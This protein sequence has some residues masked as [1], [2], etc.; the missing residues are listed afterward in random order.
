MLKVDKSSSDTIIIPA[1]PTFLVTHGGDWLGS[2][3]LGSPATPTFGAM[4]R[5][6]ARRHALSGTVG[7]A[8]KDLAIWGGDRLVAVLRRGANGRLKIIQV[9]DPKQL[10]L[11]AAC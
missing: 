8:G 7:F 11:A 10:P 9:I 3:R 2:Y 6:I 5:D 4:L 1:G